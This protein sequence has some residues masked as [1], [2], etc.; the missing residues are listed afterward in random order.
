MEHG[1]ISINKAGTGVIMTCEQLAA[2][3]FMVWAV[4]EETAES[5]IEMQVDTILHPRWLEF[6]KFCHS[7]IDFWKC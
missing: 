3:V 2:T 6:S 4:Q 7:F 1:F 5:S